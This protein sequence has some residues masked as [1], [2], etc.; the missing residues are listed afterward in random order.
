MKSSNAWIS[1]R[2]DIMAAAI[3]ALSSS[4]SLHFTADANDVFFFY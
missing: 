2:G 4:Y 3:C 1:E